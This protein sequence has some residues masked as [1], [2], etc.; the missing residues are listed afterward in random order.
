LFQRRWNDVGWPNRAEQIRLRAFDPTSLP[1]YLPAV[2]HG[3]KRRNDLPSP[4]VAVGTFDILRWYK[5]EGRLK[6]IVNSPSSLRAR[7]R[8][9]AGTQVILVSVAN[10]LRVEM[11]WARHRAD[12]VVAALRGLGIAGMT[13]PNFSFFEDAPRIHTIW[14]RWRMIRVAQRIS[15]AG[16]AVIP[17]LNALEERDWD[18]W[19]EFLREHTNVTCIAKEFQTGNSK[20]QNAR[21]AIDDIK[22][23]EQRIGRGL[24]PIL[25]GAGFMWGEA[26]ACLHR[27]TLMDSR[28]FMQTVHRRRFVN[29]A[30]RRKWYLER[31]DPDVYLDAML[32]EN[33]RSYTEWVEGVKPKPF[34]AP[35]QHL[36]RLRPIP[37]VHSVPVSA[38]IIPVSDEN[39][40]TPE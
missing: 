4:L 40:G 16:I 18:F 14:N 2:R 19:T 12:D 10:D 7:L 6:P 38:S 37:A 25:V 20:R 9:H 28:P 39:D 22:R 17:H 11:F 26:K 35:R 1:E 30:G 8:L 34:H 27:L 31:T 29:N 3:G 15:E 32:E 5:R 21:E 23:L 24:H 13:V 36:L 33:I